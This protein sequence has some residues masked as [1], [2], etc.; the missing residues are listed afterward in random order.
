MPCRVMWTGINIDITLADQ[1]RL[2]AIVEA[3]SSPQKHVWRATIILRSD[4]G[5]GSA[6]IMAASGKSKTVCGAGKN[7]SWPRASTACCATR[8]ARRESR[9]CVRG[10]GSSA[11]PRLNVR[12]HVAGKAARRADHHLQRPPARAGPRCLSAARTSNGAES[13]VTRSAATVQARSLRATAGSASWASSGET[14][15][16]TNFLP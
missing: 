6:G 2:R 14:P 10:R 12:Q 11:R 15:P 5:A 9:R 16:S 1:A 13:I 4:Q 3:R 8:A 7:V